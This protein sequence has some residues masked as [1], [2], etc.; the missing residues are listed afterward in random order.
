MN[1]KYVRNP[2]SFRKGYYNNIAYGLLASG[3]FRILYE[4]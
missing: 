1:Q 2:Y 3:V 4:V